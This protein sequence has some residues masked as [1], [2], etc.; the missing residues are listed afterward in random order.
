MSRSGLLD[1]TI[2]ELGRLLAM[3]PDESGERILKRLRAA[4]D[5]R[6]DDPA[7]SFEEVLE[8]SSSPQPG[9]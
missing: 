4:R 6:F 2:A 1:A 8:S 3:H 7:F 9:E 5:N